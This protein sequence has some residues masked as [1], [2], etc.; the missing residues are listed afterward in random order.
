MTTTASSATQAELGSEFRMLIDGALVESSAGTGF[1]N[2][3]PATE[4]VIG[5]TTDATAAAMERAIVAA[6]RCA[7][8]PH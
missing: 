8:A 2:L 3:T 1:D 7:Q 6:R 5:Q 4:A